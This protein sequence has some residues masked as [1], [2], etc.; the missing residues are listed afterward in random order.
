[1][2]DANP[3]FE[4]EL[5]GD[6]DERSRITAL[7]DDLGLG[8]RV[9]ISG[10]RSDVRSRL[11]LADVF[12]MSSLSEGISLTVLEA[13]AEGLPTVVTTVGG[14]PEIVV[15]GVTGRLVP[16]REPIVFAKAVLEV[17]DDPARAARMGVA[18]RR[19][20]EEHFD[21]RRMV[22]DYEALYDS[23]LARSPSR[24]SV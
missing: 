14:N 21:V 8:D 7:R 19:R 6:G 5:V 10:A 18:G 11:E 4:L 22:R 13:M 12:V 20:V 16:P 15:D 1:V 2:A 24:R 9:H 17:L 23:L 3:A